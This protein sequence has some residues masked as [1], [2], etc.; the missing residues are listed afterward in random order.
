MTPDPDLHDPKFTAE[1]ME[2]HNAF[3][4]EIREAIKRFMPK[5]PI[6]DEEMHDLPI[7]ALIMVN[8]LTSNMLLVIRALVRSGLMKPEGPISVLRRLEKKL[9]SL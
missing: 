5:D 9:M 1:Q 7:T 2:R 3:S 4:A 8:A 6:S